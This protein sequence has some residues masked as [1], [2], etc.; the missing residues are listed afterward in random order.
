VVLA[1]GQQFSDIPMAFP[2]TLN[3]GGGWGRV[4]FLPVN[5]LYS[6]PEYTVNVRLSRAL[7]FGERLKGKLLF[8]AFNL[9]N[10]QYDTGVNTVAYVATGGVL[11]PVPRLGA[12]NASHGYPNGTNA[13]SCQVSFRLQF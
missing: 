10:S 12:G 7:P 9:S 13:R 2:T 6:G 11:T 5:S 8:E 3:G 4:P 1:N